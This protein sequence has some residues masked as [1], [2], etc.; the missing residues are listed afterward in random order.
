MTTPRCKQVRELVVIQ[1]SRSRDGL[2]RE[3]EAWLDACIAPA[4]RALN[5][6]GFETSGS[7]CG[8]GKTVPRV[9]L[10]DGSEVWWDTA[11]RA[12][13]NVRGSRAEPSVRAFEMVMAAPRRKLADVLA[14]LSVEV[15]SRKE[16]ATP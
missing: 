4:V 16:K 7:C 1:A 8:H 12:W 6:A 11:G 2:K 13:L 10:A 9:M 5:A 15:C 3:E 14:R